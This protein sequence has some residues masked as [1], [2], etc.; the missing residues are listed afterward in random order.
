MELQSGKK[1]TRPSSGS[2]SD[3]DTGT[4]LGSDLGSGT[5][6]G[7]DLEQKYSMAFD[8]ICN[9]LRVKHYDYQLFYEKVV[10]I[11]AT[12][13]IDIAMDSEIESTLS[14]MLHFLSE[15]LNIHLPRSG[16]PSLESLARK[17]VIGGLGYS[18]MCVLERRFDNEKEVQYAYLVKD[19]IID[20]MRVFYYMFGVK[21]LNDTN[22]FVAGR[23]EY[24][25]DEH[26]EVLHMCHDF[27]L[28]LTEDFFD[29]GYG[30]VMA[31][32]HF[33][34]NLFRIVSMRQFRR[35]F[36][37]QVCLEL[38]GNHPR[39]LGPFSDYYNHLRVRGTALRI[40]DVERFFVGI[41][42]PY[43]ATMGPVY[44]RFANICM[45]RGKFVRYAKYCA[46]FCEICNQAEHG[47]RNQEIRYF[48][49]CRELHE[50]GR[51]WEMF[52]RN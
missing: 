15:L 2:G 19:V 9:D 44:E 4:G 45:R 31:M 33:L 50:T 16:A 5:G 7:L 46:T 18:Y 20:C 37:D 12:T 13:P 26:G 41:V 34:A 47:G 35:D 51:L 38:E 1:R 3:M 11:N 49:H 6:S 36:F 32:N 24:L 10:R 29:G 21:R 28:R 8:V 23:G 39:L 17:P 30:H 14:D 22:Y 40:E 25:A 43:L 48:F 52:G 42:G 27:I